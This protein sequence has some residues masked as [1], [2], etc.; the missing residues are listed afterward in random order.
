MLDS[1][2]GSLTPGKLADII[3]I[4]TDDL[5]LHPVNDPV[6]SVVLFA[7]ASNV[8]TVFVAGCKVKKGGQLVY[9]SNELEQKKARLSESTA[10]ILQEAGYKHQFA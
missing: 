5:N 2:I 6:N 1:K 7:N 10:R 4:R 3:L 8:D 9:P